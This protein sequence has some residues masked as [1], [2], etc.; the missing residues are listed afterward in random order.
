MSI[1]DRTYARI[2]TTL[3]GY[4]RIIPKIQTRPLFT[5][6]PACVPMQ[7]LDPAQAQL[8]EA[9]VSQLK[10]MDEKLSAVLTLLSR[11]AMRDDFPIPVI[12]HDISGAGLRFSS[13]HVFSLG[14]HVEIVVSLSMYPLG[15]IGTMGSIIRRDVIEDTTLWAVEFKDIRDT[16][17]EKIIQYVIAE[18]REQIR[19]R[20]STQS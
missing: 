3:K 14:E 20:R 7:P 9:L 8:P 10:T 6:C 4:L 5:G 15:L 1:L 18:Q 16:E 19:D 2:D 11:Q 13:E 12:I 17:R